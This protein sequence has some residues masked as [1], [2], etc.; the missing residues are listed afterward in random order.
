[1]IDQLTIVINFILSIIPEFWVDW[2]PQQLLP[3]NT[4]DFIR[5]VVIIP[6]FAYIAYLDQKDRLIPTKVW[7][8]LLVIALALLTHDFVYGAVIQQQGGLVIESQGTIQG[9]LV[10]YGPLLL[11]NI[12]L[13]AIIGFIFNFLDLFG[14][15]DLRAFFVVTLLVPWWPNASAQLIEMIQIN[16]AFPI[17]EPLGVTMI[18]PVFL[19]ILQWTALL[20]LLYP[21]YLF[22]KNSNEGTN[23]SFIEK[24]LAT[25]LS[26]E[27]FKDSHGRTLYNKNGSLTK[28]GVPSSFLRE[29]LSWANEQSPDETEFTAKDLRDR[30]LRV[31]QFLKQSDEWVRPKPEN[32]E[33]VQ[34]VED[35]LKAAIEQDTLWIMPEAPFLVPFGAGIVLTFILGSPITIFLTLL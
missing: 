2:L 35:E 25:P 18:N 9:H 10:R 16:P 14:G 21:V 22:V 6:S 3:F 15:A 13:A 33:E 12:I 30:P 20:G 5:L 26:I 17:F 7:Y 27:E 8:P 29:Y 24:V 28:D 4:T 23:G 1:M 34:E 31:Q 11:S 19:G 32:T